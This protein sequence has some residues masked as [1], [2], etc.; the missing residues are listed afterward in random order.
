MPEIDITNKVMYSE[1]VFSLQKRLEEIVLGKE[2]NSKLKLKIYPFICFY[3][4]P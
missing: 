3:D 4:L 2:N 1:L